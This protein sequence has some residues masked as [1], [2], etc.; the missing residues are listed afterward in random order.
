MKLKYRNKISIYSFLYNLVIITGFFYLILNA[1]NF[2]NFSTSKVQAY[3]T[4]LTYL[5]EEVT[6]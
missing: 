2:S 4:N 6:D 5:T 3:S 1:Y